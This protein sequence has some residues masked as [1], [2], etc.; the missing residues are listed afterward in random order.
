VLS[1]C[2]CARLLLT[3]VTTSAADMEQKLRDLWP[4]GGNTAELRAMMDQTRP[5]RRHWISVEHP[6]ASTVLSRWPRLFDVNEVV[7]T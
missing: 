5:Q 4:T 2:I 1:T 3:D 7:C 6:D